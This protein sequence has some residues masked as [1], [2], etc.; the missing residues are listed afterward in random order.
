MVALYADGLGQYQS[1]YDALW[2]SL[3]PQSGHAATL[4]GE[5]VRSVGW[6]VSITEMA[7]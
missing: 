3:V 5:I 2:Q 4:Q 7:I 6:L 1:E